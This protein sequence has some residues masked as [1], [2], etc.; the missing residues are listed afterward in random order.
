M[1]YNWSYQI[2]GTDKLTSIQ[3]SHQ[4]FLNNLEVHILEMHVDVRNTICSDVD[5][6]RMFAK[7]NHIKILAL[8]KFSHLWEN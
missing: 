4:S 5:C 6:V 7:L 1:L 2:I 3:T 8:T